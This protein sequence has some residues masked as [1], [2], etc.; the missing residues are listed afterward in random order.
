MST[1][2]RGER[3][4]KRKAMAAALKE[5]LCISPNWHTWLQSI[6]LFLMPPDCQFMLL[7]HW[8][9]KVST[10][11]FSLPV[12]SYWDVTECFRMP[13]AGCGDLQGVWA[14]LSFLFSI[15]HTWFQEKI[16]YLHQP[17]K[18]ELLWLTVLFLVLHPPLLQ[19]NCAEF[20]FFSFQLI[21]LFMYIIKNPLSF[22]QPNC[23]AWSWHFLLSFS[24]SFLSCINAAQCP[25]GRHKAACSVGAEACPNNWC[26][27]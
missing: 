14:W 1:S 16:Y 12:C 13:A 11:G 9:W 17:L 21:I 25:V 19:P 3:E 4:R 6:G 15:K 2:E 5:S 22:L 8:S 23:L 27:D 26:K 24:K 7:C 10:C 18:T 20:L